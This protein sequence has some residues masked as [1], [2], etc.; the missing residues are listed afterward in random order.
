MTQPTKRKSVPRPGNG[1]ARIAG[2]GKRIGRPPKDAKRSTADI[3]PAAR[4]ELTIL[5]LNQRGVRNN[6]L[7]TQRQ[8]LEELIHAAW[9]EYDAHIQQ[10]V[11]NGIE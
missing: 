3:G 4:Q 5:T 6:P 2:P 11:E 7:L 10:I 8:V 1:G 9:L